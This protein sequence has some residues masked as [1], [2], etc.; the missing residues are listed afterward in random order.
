MG[1]ASAAVFL[2]YKLG[3]TPD[4]TRRYLGL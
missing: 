4:E 3:D 1:L 2:G